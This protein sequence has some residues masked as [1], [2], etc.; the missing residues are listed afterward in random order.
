[1][2]KNGYVVYLLIPTSNHNYYHFSFNRHSVVYLLI[3]TSNHNGVG[4]TLVVP[5]VVYLLIPTSNHNPKLFLQSDFR[6]YIF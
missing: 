3:P 6:L 4:S 2:Y 1:M 5:N